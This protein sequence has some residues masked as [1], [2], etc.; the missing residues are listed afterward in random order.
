MSES[1]QDAILTRTLVAVLGYST[2]LTLTVTTYIFTVLTISL[3]ALHLAT[4]FTLVWRNRTGNRDDFAFINVDTETLER[5]HYRSS[6]TAPVIPLHAHLRTVIFRGHVCAYVRSHSYGLRCTT[7]SC[8]YSMVFLFQACDVRLL[9]LK[10][11]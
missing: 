3:D 6:A 11:E 7:F 5:I 4:M 2:N 8:A 9:L 1:V 10:L